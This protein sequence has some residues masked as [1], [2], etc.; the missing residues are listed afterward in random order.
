MNN[1]SDT[2]D[3]VQMRIKRV[4]TW[5]ELTNLKTKKQVEARKEVSYDDVIQL[6]LDEHRQKQEVPA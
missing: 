6:L 3:S 4:P 2:Y 1:T 5:V